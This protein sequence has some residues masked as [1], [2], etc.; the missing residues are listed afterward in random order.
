MKK[1]IIS[2]KYCWYLAKV[3]A[4]IKNFE[5]I[6]VTNEETIKKY[7]LQPGRYI[8]ISN[9]L[10]STPK[11]RFLD[12]FIL[13][14]YFQEIV[15]NYWLLQ[16]I[17]QSFVNKTYQYVD[18]EYISQIIKLMNC[19]Y[20]TSTSKSG[21]R[22]KEL[23]DFGEQDKEQMKIALPESW[24]TEHNIDLGEIVVLRNDFPSPVIL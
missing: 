10:Q 23:L 4:S 21:L 18:K 9:L 13:I 6:V 12:K 14:P 16:D 22:L 15:S 8:K 2:R 5:N 1:S 19:F 11:K 7:N 20:Q 17:I 24:L 3:T